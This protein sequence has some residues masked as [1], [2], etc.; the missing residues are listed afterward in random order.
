MLRLVTRKFSEDWLG[1]SD[2]GADSDISASSGACGR[3]IGNNEWVGLPSFIAGVRE[4]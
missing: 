3:H 4:S 2:Q 1:W